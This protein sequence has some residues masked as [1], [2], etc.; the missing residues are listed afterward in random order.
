MGNPLVLKETHIT[1]TIEDDGKAKIPTT[2]VYL[3]MSKNAK[4]TESIVAE[5]NLWWSQAGPV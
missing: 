3:N 4:E 1:K 5:L 2:I